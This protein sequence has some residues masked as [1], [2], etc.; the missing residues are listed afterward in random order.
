M[1]KFYQNTQIYK[2]VRTRRRA[3][4]AIKKQHTRKDFQIMSRVRIPMLDESWYLP[5]PKNQKR[6]KTLFKSKNLMNGGD[7]STEIIATSGAGKSVANI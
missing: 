2:Y 5:I 3:D 7:Y 4:V 6:P 1:S